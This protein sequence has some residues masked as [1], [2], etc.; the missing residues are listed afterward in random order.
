MR[1]A[2]VLSAGTIAP[3]NLIKLKLKDKILILLVDPSIENL[4][5]RRCRQRFKQL[6]EHAGCVP[7]IITFKAA[8]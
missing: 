2:L 5:D 8:I 6:A 4:I 7:K 1:F 3:I